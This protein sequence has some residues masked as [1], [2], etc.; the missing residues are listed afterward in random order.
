MLLTFGLELSTTLLDLAD[1]L[2]WVSHLIPWWPMMLRTSFISLLAICMSSKIWY[3]F[4]F[5]YLWCFCYWI[6]GRVP[7]TVCVLVACQADCSSLLA[8][9][10]SHCLLC[11]SALCDPVWLPLL[12]LVQ[13]QLHCLWFLAHSLCFSL[14]VT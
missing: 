4:S 1:T 9:P 12:L 14:L 7:S 10:L 6:V 11:L 5:V 2:L 13:F 3:Q 8:L